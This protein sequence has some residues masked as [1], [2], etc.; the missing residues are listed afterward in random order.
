[1]TELRLPESLPRKEV[2]RGSGEVLFTEGG[3]CEG[4]FVIEDGQVDLLSDYTSQ[5]KRL[6]TAGPG[7]LLGLTAFLTE[8]PYASTAVAITPVRLSQIACRDFQD[9]LTRSPEKWAI[10]LEH[11]ARDSGAAV[12]T[13]RRARLSHTK[14]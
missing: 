3:D 12:E 6:Q 7:C 4:V 5:P 2:R 8:G 1:M 14:H 9:F 13:L 11:V 10:V